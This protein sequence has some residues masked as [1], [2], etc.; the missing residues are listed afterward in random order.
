M[1]LGASLFVTALYHW[2]Y[3]AFRGHAVLQPLI[4]NGIITVGYLLM[5]PEGAHIAMHIAAM[6]HGM[7]PPHNYHR[8]PESS[9][10]LGYGGHFSRWCSRQETRQHPLPFQSSHERTPFLL[11]EFVPS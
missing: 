3:T 8:I 1:A 10:I 7:E 6:L 4:E 9:C 2:G 5:T 11:E